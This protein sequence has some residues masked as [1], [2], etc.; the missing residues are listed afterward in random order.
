[1]G[2]V[3]AELSTLYML[4]MLLVL[5]FC[6]A[7]IGGCVLCNL[8]SIVALSVLG[9]CQAGMNGNVSVVLL[10][11]FLLL[12]TVDLLG[13]YAVCVCV[14]SQLACIQPLGKWHCT[15]SVFCQSLLHKPAA[16]CRWAPCR[17]VLGWKHVCAWAA[18][19]N[20]WH[21]CWVLAGP[22]GTGE[23]G[24]TCKAYDC[25]IGTLVCYTQGLYVQVC[26]SSG[27]PGL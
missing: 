10:G 7:N 23:D 20:T 13:K 4:L 27:N 9:H 1:M 22:T 26:N 18:M 14:H 21:F 3:I 6:I 16:A 25:G 8:Q 24:R 15:A 2:F 5:L 17:M 19:K 11:A 12:G